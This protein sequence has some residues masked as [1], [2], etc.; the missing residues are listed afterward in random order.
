MDIAKRT[1]PKIIHLE[2]IGYGPELQIK[3]TNLILNDVKKVAVDLN[4]TFILLLL[5]DIRLISIIIKL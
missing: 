2:N 3:S 1:P 5:T 4:V